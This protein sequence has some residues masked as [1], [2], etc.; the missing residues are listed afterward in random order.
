VSADGKF[1]FLRDDIFDAQTGTLLEL[2]TDIEVLR[3]FGGEDGHNYLQAGNNV[4][5][6]QLS[7][8]ALE[9][10]EIA[11]W[12]APQRVVF[13]N[14]ITPI[15]AGVHPDGT[16]WMLY[17][18]PGGSTDFIWVT[19]K[20]ELLGIIE[21]NFSQ[22]QLVDMIDDK[23]AFICGGKAFNDE[24]A[25]CAAYTPG[26]EEP[27]WE[28]DLGRSGLVQGGVWTSDNL[29]LTTLT[30]KLLA[31][32]LTEEVE[33]VDSGTESSPIESEQASAIEGIERPKPDQPGII[34]TYQM[35][36]KLKEFRTD[37]DGVV[38][39]LSVKHNLYT[40][41]PD[42]SLRS[43]LSID[44]SPFRLTNNWGSAGPVIWPKITS[45]G[46]VIVISNADIVYGMDSA[47]NKLWEHEMQE[48][49]HSR[50]QHSDTDVQYLVDTK[51]SLFA[52]DANGLKWQYQPEEAPYTAADLVIGPNGHLYYTITDRGKAY[53]VSVSQEGQKLWTTQ[54]QT[55][56]IYEP[57]QITIDG[58][59]VFLKDDVFDAI[60]GDLLEFDIPFEVNEFIPGFDGRTY[61]RSGH[62]IM[63]WHN[64]PEGIQI[65]QTKPWQHDAFDNFNPS[66]SAVDENQL[67]WLFYQ[68]SFTAG[69]GT[70][71]VWVTLQGEVKESHFWSRS[72]QRLTMPDFE[73][74]R[75][76]ECGY[77]KTDSTMVCESYT[78]DPDTS[79]WDSTLTNI[80]EYE[81][82]FID[83]EYI[84]LQTTDDQLI[85]AYIGSP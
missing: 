73:N 32:G 16:A 24:F 38:Y 54:A 68:G 58:Q 9:V 22:G 72:S 29:Y 46:I 43:T 15:D 63:E 82:G 52:F 33:I 81:T 67:I 64:S 40:F 62:T 77:I 3:Y 1:V 39:A 76:I 14:I 51:G 84:Y 34:W 7:G 4:I 79:P 8:N 49:P 59:Y 71:L 56:D 10:V 30:G 57:V 17:S 61:L 12:N 37:E 25:E 60:T 2:E 36:E 74:S 11:E 35:P 21:H 5:L 6:W 27:V 80:P 65:L 53:V 66:G 26:A 47:D 83:G 55:R 85:A 13:G 19:L 48:E 20:D 75:F 42:G 18:S 45:D 70:Q 50:P 23:T 41:E 78:P 69:Y 44:P 28:I 31:V